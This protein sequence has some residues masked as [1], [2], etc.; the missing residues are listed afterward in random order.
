MPSLADRERT[1]YTDVFQTIETYGD[2]SPGEQ[3]LSLFLQMSGV[4]RGTVLEK[5]RRPLL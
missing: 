1:L 4:T 5:S 2:N 3:F